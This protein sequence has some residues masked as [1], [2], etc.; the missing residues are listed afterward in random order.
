[1]IAKGLHFPS[2]TLVGVLNA[3]AALHIPDFRAAESVF[4]LITQVAGRSGRSSL[5]GEVVIQTQLPE[6]PTIQ[7]AAR[8]DYPA[9]YREEI[10]SRRSFNFPPACH[11]VKLIF[12][13]KDSQ[14]T[15]NYGQEIRSFLITQLPPTYE[16]HP[17]IPCGYAKIKDQ[18]RFQCLLK[19][20]S[21]R[22]I[23]D[24]L[25]NIKKHPHIRLLIDVDP[26]STFF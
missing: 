3:D 20:E 13:G 24:L 10:E 2:V 19:G 12:T 17:V 5:K 26:L 16:L 18:F 23:T 25:K 9:F 1:M 8:L 4:Q 15:F 22:P 7:H 11:L 14:A 21:P 6:H